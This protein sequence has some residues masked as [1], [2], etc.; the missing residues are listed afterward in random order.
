MSH[1]CPKPDVRTQGDYGRNAV[2][3]DIHLH[4]KSGPK[5]RL[6]KLFAVQVMSD[7]CN[8]TK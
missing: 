4:T 3:Y 1:L 7:L 5:T 6:T 2:K 8:S